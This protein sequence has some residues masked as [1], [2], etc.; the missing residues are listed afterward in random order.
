MSRVRSIDGGY[1]RRVV[2]FEVVYVDEEEGEL[3]ML[4]ADAVNVAFERVRGVRTFPSY[5]GQRNYPGL[6]YAATMD[7]HVGF[8]SWLERDMPM[9]LDHDADVAGFASQPFWLFGPAGT[10]RCPTL[11]T[12]SLEPSTGWGS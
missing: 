6:Y 4:L 2:G 8:E 3:R 11:P 5:R 1:P 9:V 7:R 12:F 10:G